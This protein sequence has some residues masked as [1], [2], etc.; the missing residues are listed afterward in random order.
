MHDHPGVARA[1]AGAAATAQNDIVGA[2][3]GDRGIRR[4]RHTRLTGQRTD[5]GIFSADRNRSCRTFYG[6]RIK[7]RNTAR[8]RHAAAFATQCDR[9]AA[10]I[11]HCRVERNAVAGFVAGKARCAW[12]AG[13]HDVAVAAVER[14]AG[15]CNGAAAGDRSL[16]IRI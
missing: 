6:T 11:Q 1:L 4:D 13:Q 3:C 10:G 9:A 7:Q 15:Q 12:I 5:V 8:V 14:R 2:R 16:Q